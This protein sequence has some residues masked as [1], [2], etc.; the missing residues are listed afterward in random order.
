VLRRPHTG[1][2]ANNAA[3]HSNDPK[4]EMHHEKTLTVLTLTVAALP[5]LAQYTDPR[6]Q[7]STAKQLQA[8]GHDK[9]F[10]VRRG[11]ITCQAGSDN[12]PLTDGTGSQRV[13]AN[14]SP[15]P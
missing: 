9:Q 5:A 6:P 15:T 3:A 12:D 8:N 10:V 4:K 1:P 14:L 7:T 11:H 2:I 13:W